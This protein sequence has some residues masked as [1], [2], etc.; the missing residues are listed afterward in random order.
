VLVAQALADRHQA[1]PILHQ[2]HRVAMAELVERTG[3][4]CRAA[5]CRPPLLDCLV[6]Q[7]LTVTILERPK[8]RPVTRLHHLQ[9]A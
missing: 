7:R 1:H 6:A 8:Q 5:V 2:R 3:Y 9:I 4:P